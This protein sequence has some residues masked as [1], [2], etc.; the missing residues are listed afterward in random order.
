MWIHGVD[1]IAINLGIM[2]QVF[3]LVPSV[4]QVFHILLSSTCQ[5]VGAADF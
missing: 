1:W 4:W 3:W 5:A 2:S